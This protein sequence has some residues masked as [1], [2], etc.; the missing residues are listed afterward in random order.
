MRACLVW[1]ALNS[2]TKNAI[3]CTYGRY[4]QRCKTYLQ[5]MNCQC[6]FNFWIPILL[7]SMS[8]FHGA[9]AV[10]SDLF[11]KMWSNW[12]PTCDQR[13][14][15]FANV[16]CRGTPSI[17]GHDTTGRKQKAT[18]GT[19]HSIQKSGVGLSKLVVSAF[20]IHFGLYPPSF[21]L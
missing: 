21:L 19:W 11:Q 2:A 5:D 14:S 9:E 4:A 13:S 20:E 3:T 8:N 15:Q 12:A 6:L 17:P 18:Q 10:S 16:E 7:C 1:L